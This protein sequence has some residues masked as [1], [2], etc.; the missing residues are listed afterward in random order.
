MFMINVCVVVLMMVLMKRD[1]RTND[2]RWGL[3][4]DCFCFYSSRF[5]V[6]KQKMIIV[7]Y[8]EILDGQGPIHYSIIKQ[9]WWGQTKVYGQSVVYG[10]Y[11][12]P[13]EFKIE[14]SNIPS[15]TNYQIKIVSHWNMSRG[16]FKMI[17]E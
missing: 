13:N 9:N 10:N 4:I 14:I 12:K 8:Q 3:G 17:M 1:K 15:G 2:I 6:S 5:T 11:K 7:G 16:K